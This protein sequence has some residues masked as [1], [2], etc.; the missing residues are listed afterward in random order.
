MHLADAFIQSNLQ[1]HSGY[2][3]FCQYM[4]SLEIEPT[5]F[6]AGDAT[7]YHWATQEHVVQFT[8]KM[9]ALET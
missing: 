3:F 1:L 5:T 2:T 9:V 7:L 4:C 6:C 8:L